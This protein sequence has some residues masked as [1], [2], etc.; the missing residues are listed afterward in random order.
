MKSHE[1]MAIARNANDAVIRAEAEDPM[2]VGI[3]VNA[4]CYRFD[5][6]SVIMI[7]GAQVYAYNDEME[8]L[9]DMGNE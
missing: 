3:N 9:E 2:I 6:G 8:L 7:S 4:T 5:D 1:I